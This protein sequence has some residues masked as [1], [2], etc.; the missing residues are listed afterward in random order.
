MLETVRGECEP[1]LR[2]RAARAQAEA[3]SA[4][5]VSA[6]HAPP[7]SASKTPPQPTPPQPGFEGARGPGGHRAR[8]WGSAAPETRSRLPGID[9][10]DATEFPSLGISAGAGRGA[11]SAAP[12]G[13]GGGGRGWGGEG[14]RRRLEN[15]LGPPSPDNAA[16]RPASALEPKP[17]KPPKRVA[18]VA[19]NPP[20]PAIGGTNPP[21]NVAATRRVQPTAMAP[22]SVVCGQSRAR[23]GQTQSL[24]G[25]E[26]P[27]RPPAVAPNLSSPGPLTPPPLRRDSPASNRLATAASSSS[28]LSTGFS[29]MNDGSGSGGGGGGTPVGFDE[30]GAASDED[31]TDEDDEE[32]GDGGS[33]RSLSRTARNAARLHAAALGGGAVPDVSR[34]LAL[35]CRLLALP[36]S[37]RVAIVDADVSEI[38]G[39]TNQSD[40]VGQ[41][42]QSDLA[43][44]SSVRGWMRT[45]AAARAYAAAVL[46]GCGRCVHAMGEPTLAA[47]A[48]CRDLRTLAPRL[49][50][51]LVRELGLCRV[52]KSHVS[53]RLSESSRR[54][55][56]GVML[57]AP[58][59]AAAGP[60]PPLK[61]AAAPS[62]AAPALAGR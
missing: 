27:S 38:V 32:D 16:A 47:L 53:T 45:G 30:F 21:T 58:L 36:R 37:F 34:E 8:G 13:G 6:R 49:H 43:K 31:N 26:S 50:A 25:P 29:P 11:E 55:S 40:I 57:P 2:L 19:M 44:A 59:M 46:Q 35:P 1:A 48:G 28:S 61:G 10:D 3:A 60:L 17:R 52:A 39:R 5:A 24:T 4:A 54:G 41:T 42:N 9:I 33:E 62:A 20:N 23:A 15:E 56:I 14:L 22:S 7:A 12:G 51:S 18:P